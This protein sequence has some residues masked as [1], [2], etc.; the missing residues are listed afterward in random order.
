MSRLESSKR[1]ILSNSASSAVVLILNLSVLIWLQQFLLHH[2]SQEE[3]ALLPLVTAVM[4]FAPV[5]TCVLTA[6]L[7]RYMTLAYTREDDAEVTRIVSTMFPVCSAVACA[8]LILGGLIALN[9]DSILSIDPAQSTKAKVMLC[10]LLIPFAGGLALAPFCGGFVLRQRLML[11]DGIGVSCQL[12]RLALLFSLLFGVGA[13]VL[14]VVVAQVSS[15]SIQIGVTTYVS[16]KLV[17]AQ[18]LKKGQ[19]RWS[20]VRDLGRYG[21]WAF[22]MQTAQSIKLAMDPFLLN[23]FVR[24]DISAKSRALSAFHV[25]GI[26]PR[27]LAQV[28]TPLLRP[29]IPVFAQQCA[30]GDF[31]ASRRLYLRSSRYAAWLTLVIAVPVASLS[32][33]LLNAYLTTGN[34][35]QELI[36]TASNVLMLL[37]CALAISSL[38]A[39]ASCVSLAYGEVRGMAV[40]LM[41][42]QTVNLLLTVFLVVRMEYGATGAALGSLLSTAAVEPVLVGGFVLRLLG[43]SFSEWFKEVVLPCALPSLLSALTCMAL[44]AIHP[45]N[46]W[47]LLIVYGG[48]SAVAFLAVVMIVLRPADIADLELMASR[49]PSEFLRR[50][51]QLILRIAKR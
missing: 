19:F 50:L 20:L 36:S 2:I 43:S 3:Y 22:L 32:R 30:L 7:G 1:I 17:P 47:L 35:D 15:Q 38:Y 26:A 40:R 31:A 49:F 13:N 5:I 37:A 29:L 9:L 27:Q 42:L 39:P 18:R 46:S 21:S 8:V 11:E 48:I 14:W 51:A 33:Q 12:L 41:L 28:N 23:R 25:G 24:P 45:A 44:V 6:G 4:L 10:L 16:R 34:V